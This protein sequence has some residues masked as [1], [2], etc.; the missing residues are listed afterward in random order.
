VQTPSYRAAPQAARQTEFRLPSTT[1]SR[2]RGNRTG[3]PD[4]SWAAREVRQEIN[5]TRREGHFLAVALLWNRRLLRAHNMGGQNTTQRNSLRSARKA[6]ASCHHFE[7]I[8]LDRFRWGNAGLGVRDCPSCDKSRHQSGGADCEQ[9][10]GHL[11]LSRSLVCTGEIARKTLANR[12]TAKLGP[13]NYH[14]VGRV[15]LATARAT[16]TIANLNMIAD[17]SQ[18]DI[19]TKT[20]SSIF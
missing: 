17:P 4:P 9:C 1:S 13:S 10:P 5:Q 8:D 14:Y 6:S 7:C 20:P 19:V 2:P 15:V 12:R 16:D 3:R 18:F 11:T